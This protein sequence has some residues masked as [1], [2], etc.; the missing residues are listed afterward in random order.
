ML[1]RDSAE[2]WEGVCAQKPACDAQIM[3]F[4]NR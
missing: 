4:V 1:G 2:G 3:G